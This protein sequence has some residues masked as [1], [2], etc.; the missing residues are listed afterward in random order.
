MFIK[1]Y[2]IIHLFKKKKRKKDEKLK[3]HNMKFYL[4]HFN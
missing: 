2:F 4:I 3:H 1:I